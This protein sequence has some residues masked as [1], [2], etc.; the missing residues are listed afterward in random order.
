MV[1]AVYGQ[2]ASVWLARP[3]AHDAHATGAWQAQSRGSRSTAHW[4][5]VEE[6]FG[7][8]RKRTA[9]AG[10]EL[11]GPAALA[12]HEHRQDSTGA[13]VTYYVTRL[14]GMASNGSP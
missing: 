3:V 1:S 2:P 13:H 14:P 5:S 7:A 11:H 10:I 6:D 8:G 12:G 4:P 9:D